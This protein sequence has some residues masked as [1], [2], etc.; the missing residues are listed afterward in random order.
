MGL[1][2]TSL[3]G[4]LMNQALRAGGKYTFSAAQVMSSPGEFKG[5]VMSVMEGQFVVISVDRSSHK[6]ENLLFEIS[7]ILTQANVH[8]TNVHMNVQ[9]G[10]ATE[11]GLTNFTVKT[12]EMV[13][14]AQD[15]QQV[16]EKQ[17]EGEK[18]A[19]QQQEEKQA[20]QEVEEVKK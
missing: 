2:V 15:Q 16:E 10:G 1:V 18:K 13:K 4:Y 11:A 12:V 8:I 3:A 19:Q 20:Q 17:E 5:T 9:L 6:K 14:K 7:K